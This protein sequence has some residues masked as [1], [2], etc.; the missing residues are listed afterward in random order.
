MPQADNN[1]DIDLGFNEYTL[2]R[3]G[4]SITD[5]AFSPNGQMLASADTSEVQIFELKNQSLKQIDRIMKGNYPSCMAWS[6]DGERLAIG[7]VSTG[8]SAIIIWDSSQRRISKE[9]QGHSR[10]IASI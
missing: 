1:V 7:I 2:Q 9:L 5:F 6:Q 10:E 3:P 8:S 4:K